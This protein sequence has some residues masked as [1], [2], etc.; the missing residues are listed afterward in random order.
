MGTTHAVLVV[1]LPLSSI[2]L[3]AAAMDP[4]QLPKWW[5]AVTA[6]L[7]GLVTVAIEA[8]RTGQLTLPAKG[9][10]IV[11]GVFAIALIASVTVSNEQV[12]AVIG[13]YSRWN[14]AAGY[15]AY[16]TLGLLA[17][18]SVV[19]DERRRRLGT[20]ILATA[21]VVA[22]YAVLQRVGI[23]PLP[24]NNVYAPD[25]PSF[26]G[27]PNFASAFLGIPFPLIVARAF[28]VRT[29][30]KRF[31]LGA[32]AL[33]FLAGLWTTGSWIG[34]VSISAGLAVMAVLM[35]VT[36]EHQRWRRVGAIAGM[37]GPLL[38]VAVV[39]ALWTG[40]IGVAGTVATRLYYW[41]TAWAM[42]MDHPM[43]GVGL[44]T[45]EDQFRRYRPVDE[46]PQLA[47]G[48]FADNPHNVLL[49]LAS[50]GGLLV[51]IPWL[52]LIAGIGAVVVRWV[53]DQRSDRR[54]R[55]DRLTV[56]AWSGAFCGYLVQALASFDVPSLAVLG[57]VIGGVVVALTGN[58]ERIEVPGTSAVHRVLAGV[59]SMAAVGL[60][61]AA[62]I[63][64]TANVEAGEGL[65]AAAADDYSA[66]LGALDTAAERAWWEPRYRFA[67]GQVAAD[68]GDVLN[69]Q[70]RFETTAQRFDQILQPA[71]RSARVAVELGQMD[72][73]ADWY[74]R[75]LALEPNDETLRS[76]AREIID[77]ATDAP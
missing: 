9:F 6:A 42:F 61:V 76:E 60:I 68:V 5:I 45:F 18:A 44:G 36:G 64:V 11:S 77:S 75:V 47:A 34:L 55:H 38:A 20:V 52:I 49:A 33:L 48:A 32:L 39:W 69:A 28:S 66:A 4:S 63:P 62:S 25:S 26:L 41:K 37:S 24:W 16:L 73:A 7:V 17:A 23:D 59:V 53:R 19:T 65:R 46:F 58:H 21:S 30:K 50:E 13:G 1:V 12:R 22:T 10:L 72:R 70:I 35:A 67:A 31:G 27:N 56:A 57:F 8:A 15:L 74:R 40:V 43:I 54:P 3:L 29:T 71:L 51:A 2:T 14:G